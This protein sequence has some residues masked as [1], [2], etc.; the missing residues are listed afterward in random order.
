M[1]TR[2]FYEAPGTI[3]GTM[4]GLTGRRVPIYYC[5]SDIGSDQTQGTYQRCRG[6]YVVNWGNSK[7][8]W[9]I[10]PPGIAPFSHIRG[11]RNM[12]RDTNYR[13]IIDGLSKTLIMSEVLKAWSLD[14]NDWRGDIHND[15]GVCRF[16]TSVTPNSSVRDIIESGWFQNTGDPLM[17]AQAGP[18]TGQVAAARSRHPGGVVAS[19]CDGSTHFVTNEIDLDIWQA[20]G[21][22]NGKE[23]V[24]LGL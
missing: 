23:P 1:I 10:E 20:S 22:M 8:G 13:K 12:P 11:R 4:N 14:D 9:P 16:H 21:T 18:R 19:M 2:N 7:Y 17:P 24:S 5:P 3:A 15:D 6:N